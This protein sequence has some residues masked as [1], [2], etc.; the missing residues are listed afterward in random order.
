MMKTIRHQIIHWQ[1]DCKATG[2]S[3]SPVSKRQAG[4]NWCLKMLSVS[5]KWEVVVDCWVEEVFLYALKKQLVHHEHCPAPQAAPSHT[6]M[7]NRPKSGVLHAAG[8]QLKLRFMN[9]YLNIFA[10]RYAYKDTFQVFTS[11][12]LLLA[13]FFLLLFFPQNTLFYHCKH[14]H[15]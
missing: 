8:R 13:R 9:I 11:I 6:D 2:E 1:G 12:N 4:E 10:Y 7:K 5:K 15:T 14:K 3:S